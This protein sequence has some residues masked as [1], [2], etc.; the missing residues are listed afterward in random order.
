MY[1]SSGPSGHLLPSGEGSPVVKCTLC[2]VRCPMYLF[3][4]PNCSGHPRDH[5]FQFCIQPFGN[6]NKYIGQRTGLHPMDETRSNDKYPGFKLIVVGLVGTV[7]KPSMFFARLIQ[8]ACG[9]HQEKVP[10][11]SD[12]DFLSCGSFN[13]P[14]PSES[15]FLFCY[16][17]LSL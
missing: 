2:D 9:N 4:L 15:F 10:K 1:P 14:S 5:S 6:R 11:A 8:A 13:K 16:F 12:S 17:F 3:R 7:D